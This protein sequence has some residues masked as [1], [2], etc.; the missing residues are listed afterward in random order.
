MAQK[1]FMRATHALAEAA[2]RCGCKLYFGYPITPITEVGEYWAEHAEEH[3]ASPYMVES[4][5]EAGAMLLGASA[6]GARVMFG[7]TGVG[8]S[9]IAESMST[10]AGMELPMVLADFPRGD[11]GA[12]TLGFGQGDYFQVTRA[13]AQGNFHLITLSPHTV[14]ECV[15]LT[16]D[17]FWLADKHRVPVVV[18]GDWILGMSMEAVSFPERDLFAG[19]EPKTWALDG[20]MSRP[21]RHVVGGSSGGMITS[22]NL[23]DVGS[24]TGATR[25]PESPT[26]RKVRWLHQKYAQI[27][28]R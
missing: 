17:A 28:R 24:E 12:G 13:A 3:G 15:D 19:L 22:V 5:L 11:M 6:S 16:Y 7:S 18:M 23:G 25:A 20:D 26:E 27:P 9:L 1:R 14:Q 21:P 4:E 2:L 8:I 10:M